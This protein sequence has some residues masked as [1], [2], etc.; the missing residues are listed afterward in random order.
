[1]GRFCRDDLMIYKI[2]RRK[3]HGDFVSVQRMDYLDPFGNFPQIDE[4]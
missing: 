4:Y 2:S 3:L 1:M